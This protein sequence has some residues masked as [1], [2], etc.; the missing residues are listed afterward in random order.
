MDFFN[1]EINSSKRI[2]VHERFQITEN[3]KK[4]CKAMV[5]DFQY[6]IFIAINYF[7]LVSLI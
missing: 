3:G 5:K 2:I 7:H 1:V 4:K 6:N